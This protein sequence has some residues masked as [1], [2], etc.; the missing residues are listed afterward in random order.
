MIMVLVARILQA[1]LLAVF[2][3]GFYSNAFAAA[4]TTAMPDFG[5]PPSLSQMIDQLNDQSRTEPFNRESVELHSL[6][7]VI[8]HNNEALAAFK[9][10]VS[11][12]VDEKDDGVS[13]AGWAGI[14][15]LVISVCKIIYDIWS[16]NNEKRSSKRDNFWLREII[17]PKTIEPLDD[18][19]LNNKIRFQD[20]SKL[21]PEELKRFIDGFENLRDQVGLVTLLSPELLDSIDAAIDGLISVVANKAEPGSVYNEQL[22]HGE[23]I[24]D[25]FLIC[26]KKIIGHFMD[27]H[28]RKEHQM[29]SA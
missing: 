2:F 11:K 23:A 3:M 29:V 21:T 20:F 17:F 5:E 27:A 12:I 8:E 13:A 25:P 18:A 7:S 10:L 24:G 6:S 16:K 22:E 14:L 9:N 26:Y 4:G 1:L 28:E 19:I 15:G